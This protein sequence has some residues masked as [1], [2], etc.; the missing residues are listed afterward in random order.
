MRRLSFLLAVLLVAGCIGGGGGTPQ[1]TNAVAIMKFQPDATRVTEQ[2]PVDLIIQLKNDGAFD[3]ENVKALLY[4]KGGFEPRTD[5]DNP[6]TKE[7]DTLRAPNMQTGT[8]GEIVEHRWQLEAPEIGAGVKTYPFKFMVDVSYD[9]QSSSWKRVP[10]IKHQRIQEIQASGGA[11][12]K[13]DSGRQPAPIR[14]DINTYEPITYRDPAAQPDVSNTIEIKVLLEKVAPGHVKEND[15]IPQGMECSERLNCVGRVIL[16]IPESLLEFGSQCD[17]DSDL[18]V[19]VEEDG[20]SGKEKSFINLVDGTKAQLK[21]KVDIKETDLVNMEGML[22]DEEFA[23]IKAE[24]YYTY[25]TSGS[26]DIEVVKI[27][28]R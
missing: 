5:S 27:V 26:T 15:F 14:M 28:G 2:D 18:S 17:F 19:G 13:S 3:A 24:A 8:G 4:L 20:Y 6:W 25:H 7:F 16:K 9:Y 11:M 23:T 12:P 22:A 10:I 21:C 1:S